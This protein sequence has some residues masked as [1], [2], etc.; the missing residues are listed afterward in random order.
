LRD[1]DRT[2]K[3]NCSNRGIKGPAVLS[4]FVK[5]PEQVLLD[6]MHT[7]ARGA[8][9]NLNN[10]WFNPNFSHKP[11]YIGSPT[12]RAEI[13]KRFSGVKYPMEFHRTTKS[14]NQFNTLK[15]SELENMEFYIGILVILILTLSY[16]IL[17]S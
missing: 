6:K 10:L 13:D 2:K 1:V 16:Q 5:I 3:D 8:Q 7:T 4:E 17:I 15:C 14:I 11:W 9:E 12:L